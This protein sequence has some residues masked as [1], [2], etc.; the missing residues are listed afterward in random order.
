MR[1]MRGGAGGGVG[2][3]G[4][5]VGGVGAA[6]SAP[7]TL[8]G[9]CMSYSAEA[10]PTKYLVGTDQGV[11][12]QVNTR[13]RSKE[14]GGGGGGVVLPVAHDHPGGWHH[15]ATR[16]ICRHPE[17]GALSRFFLTVGDW[18]ARVWDEVLLLLA[19]D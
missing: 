11:V 16:S 4:G 1:G 14:H 15:G 9:L 2:G 5:G 17:G 13:N 7:K 19:T 18:T 6:A 3:I 10:G 12:L 8:G